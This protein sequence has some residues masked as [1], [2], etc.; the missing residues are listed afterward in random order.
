MKIVFLSNYLNHHQKPVS[1]ELY[2]LTEG[3][4]TYIDTAPMSE[5]RRKLGYKEISA[6]YLIKCYNQKTPPPQIQSIID[7]A[8][9]VIIGSAPDSYILN[10]TK[11]QKLTF[12][13]AERLYRQDPG[14]LKLLYHRLRFWRNYSRNPNCCL[15]CASAFT[16]GDFLRLGC[17]KNRAFKW[18]YFPAV[19]AMNPEKSVYSL[20][21]K[22]KFLWV[23]R[24]LDW[25]HP[26]IPILMAEQIKNRGV[27]FEVNMYGVG[28]ELES[29]KS[30]VDKKSLTDYVK[31]HGAVPNDEI[32]RQM[33]S[34][35]VFLFT[36][37]RNEGWGA[38][39]NEAMSSG[40]A[41]VANKA[42]GS[43]PYLIQDGINGLTYRDGDFED[44]YTK[45]KTLI[46]NQ[47][48]ITELQRNAYSTM[49]NMWNPANAASR[50]IELASCILENK[51][52]PF[53]EGVCSPAPIIKD[54]NF[55]I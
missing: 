48:L 36:S 52:N 28:P 3:Q 55:T 40:C 53:K 38:V 4:Y 13:Y 2:R 29:I 46:N 15:L 43:V 49:V 26:E 30:M 39:L 31:I 23:G 10:R 50:L 20:D 33:Q 47:E 37:D 32:T 16:A 24:F 17:F 27:N 19:A 44:F 45:V 41:V 42:I 25:K 6:P 54:A 8:D 18:G 22:T 21:V 14:L 9:V 5:E 11:Q 1:D 34:H 7:E 35:D 51:Q 12:K